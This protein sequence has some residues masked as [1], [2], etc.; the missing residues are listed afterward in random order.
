MT[1]EL[2]TVRQ[3]ATR[4]GLADRRVTE[5]VL[6]RVEPAA[7]VYP[8]TRPKI[9]LKLYD[10]ERVAEAVRRYRPRGPKRT[11]PMPEALTTHDTTPPADRPVKVGPSGLRLTRRDVAVIAERRAR[12][13][14]VFARLEGK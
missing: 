1:T 6:K 9:G 10:P 2:L 12:F 5:S 13:A 11:R 8:P 4:Y 3:I 14:D 7:V